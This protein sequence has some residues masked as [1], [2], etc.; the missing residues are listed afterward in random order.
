MFI[1]TCIYFLKHLWYLQVIFEG[2]RK[3]YP[4]R[5]CNKR[6]SLYSIQYWLFIFKIKTDR[7][8]Y[9]LI[10]HVNDVMV[11][12]IIVSIIHKQAN[13]GK[14]KTK[15]CIYQNIK[16]IDQVLRSYMYFWTCLKTCKAPLVYGQY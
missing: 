5:L 1:F 9:I 6:H 8:K 10:L 4:D 13:S 3:W 15:K 12:F 2:L 16:Y 11:C 14:H 7:L